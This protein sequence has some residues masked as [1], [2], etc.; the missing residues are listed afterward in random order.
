LLFATG[1]TVDQA[2]RRP[3]NHVNVEL[4]QQVAFAHPLPIRDP[5]PGEN[6]ISYVVKW[7]NGSGQGGIAYEI[8]EV[9]GSV[10]QLEVFDASL[11]SQRCF[12]RTL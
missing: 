1:T 12:C 3:S 10:Y 4:D 8:H 5:T 6:R 7:N 11:E 2:F 9:Y